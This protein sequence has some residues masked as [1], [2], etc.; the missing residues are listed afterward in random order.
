MT[1]EK[2][3][4]ATIQFEPTMFEKERNI[5]RLLGMTREAPACGRSIASPIPLTAIV[6][7]AA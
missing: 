4:A 1:S 7:T 2:F 5:L 3:K 6:G